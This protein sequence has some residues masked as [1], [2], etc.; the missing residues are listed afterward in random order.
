[1]LFKL[2]SW[3]AEH[4]VLHGIV[5]GGIKAHLRWNFDVA[6][7]GQLLQFKIRWKLV[8]HSAAFCCS[9]QHLIC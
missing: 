2:D 7:F 6:N 3:N 4:A 8:Q 1:M 5:I 9:S